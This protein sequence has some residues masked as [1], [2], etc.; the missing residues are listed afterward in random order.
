[1]HF[2]IKM[3]KYETEWDHDY[4]SIS[5]LDDNDSLLSFKSWTGDHWETVQQ[6]FISAETNSI[7]SQV[8]LLIE[9]H[10][11]ATVNYRGWEIYE[12]KL[13]P[14]Y[15]NYLSIQEINGQSMPKIPLKIHSLF[16]NPSY[17]KFQLGLL[18]FWW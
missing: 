15:D 14:V 6:D 11:D 2:S 8:K 13:F 9:F 12:L 3:W 5:L 17:G 18:L 7:F 10:K 4:I 1:M 16:P